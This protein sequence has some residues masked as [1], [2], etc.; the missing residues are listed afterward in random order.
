MCK[1]QTF[2]AQDAP[3]KISRSSLMAECE[4][5]G[6]MKGYMQMPMWDMGSV[7]LGL[8]SW[9]CQQMAGCLAGAKGPQRAS[10]RTYPGR[11]AEEVLSWA[12]KITQYGMV[13]RRNYGSMWQAV[14]ISLCLS[15]SHYRIFDSKK[16]EELYFYNQVLWSFFFHVYSFPILL[17]NTLYNEYD[18]L[19][20]WHKI[21]LDRLTC[22]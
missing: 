16:N 19:S 11:D 4:C 12:L 3:V 7:S 21:T 22:C 8:Q 2:S 14:F 1:N 5:V 10:S 17:Y 20:S 13:K 18:S 6:V 9:E 15:L